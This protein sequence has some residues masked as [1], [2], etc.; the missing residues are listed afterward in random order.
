ME[1]IGVACGGSDSLPTVN[2][3]I[4]DRYSD[5]RLV[6][7]LV[8]DIHSLVDWKGLISHRHS[9]ADTKAPPVGIPMTVAMFESSM[10]P[11]SIALSGLL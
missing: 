7:L 11:L 10:R 9:V 4:D 8:V 5:E 3:V 2:S 6:A 1:A